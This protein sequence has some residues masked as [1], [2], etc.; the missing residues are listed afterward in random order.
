MDKFVQQCLNDMRIIQDMLNT[1][2][3]GCAHKEISLEPSRTGE[4]DDEFIYRVTC[5][6]CGWRWV[7]DQEAMNQKVRQGEYIVSK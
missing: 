6:S 7:H 4:F 5:Q 2:R 3:K 1:Y